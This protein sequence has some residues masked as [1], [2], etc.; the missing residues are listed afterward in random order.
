MRTRVTWQ[1]SVLLDYSLVLGTAVQPLLA[2]NFEN[3]VKIERWLKRHNFNCFLYILDIISCSRDL[4]REANSQI[5]LKNS[6]TTVQRHSALCVSERMFLY[7]CKTQDVEQ[8]I[9]TLSTRWNHL[10]DLKLHL[11]VKATDFS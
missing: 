6:V 1:D 11:A 8:P 3:Q 10:L 5:F 7:G 2:L 9:K 4:T